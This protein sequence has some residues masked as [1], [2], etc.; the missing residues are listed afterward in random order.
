MSITTTDLFAIFAILLSALLSDTRDFLYCIHNKDT[1]VF[2]LHPSF[3]PSS[4]L[5][6]LPFSLL[7]LHTPLHSSWLG[8]LSRQPVVSEQPSSPSHS[9][10]SQLALPS[11]S[12]TISGWQWQHG[13]VAHALSSSSQLA[14][15]LCVDNV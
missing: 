5:A 12:D 3:L 1:L 7:P 13:T 8:L 10:P 9:L 4:S 14:V 6:P 11:A 2:L 15:S